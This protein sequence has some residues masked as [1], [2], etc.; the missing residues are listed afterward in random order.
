MSDHL[1]SPHVAPLLRCFF[2]FK[3]TDLS[4][5]NC[6][7]RRMRPGLDVEKASKS[8]LLAMFARNYQNSQ[9]DASWPRKTLQRPI[10]TAT[11]GQNPMLAWGHEGGRAIVRNACLARRFRLSVTNLQP[12]YNWGL[13]ARLSDR[14]YSI[15]HLFHNNPLGAIIA[16][17]MHRILLELRS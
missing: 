12:L 7:G 10:F 1:E 11:D 9:M 14:V 15:K 5:F 3:S 16:A 13:Y 4:R 2:P 8:S 6:R 17:L